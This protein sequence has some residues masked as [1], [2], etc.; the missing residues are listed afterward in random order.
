[1]NIY[2]DK[3]ADYLEFF[4]KHC[5]N[6]ADFDDNN[7]AIT[8]FKS[9]ADDKIVGYGLDNASKTILEFDKLNSIDKMAILLKM[10]RIK[11][12]LSQEQASQK[13]GISLRHYQRLE[14]GQDT[15]V[16]ILS[17]IIDIF[18]ETNFSSIFE[19]KKSA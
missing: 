8:I 5:K 13:L 9:N 11:K 18:P 12:D 1:M 14:S 7:E 10:S 17:H 15:T 19:A 16:S 3:E 4:L 6:Y 2:Y